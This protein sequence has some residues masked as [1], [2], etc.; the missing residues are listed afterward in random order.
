MKESRYN[1]FFQH[2]SKPDIMVCYNARTNALAKINSDLYEK[3]LEYVETKKDVLAAKELEDFI[4]GGFLINEDLDEIEILRERLLKRRYNGNTLSLTIT[5]TL[6]CNF[7][8]PYC[9]E[10]GDKPGKMTA[11]LQDKIIEMLNV[12]KNFINHFSVTWYGGE[13]L[14]A[15]DVIENLSTHFIEICKSNNIK[16]DASIVTNGYLLGRATCNK[17]INEL[18][19]TAIQITLDGPSEIHNKTRILHNGKGTFEQIL[20]N[21]KTSADLLENHTVIRTNV[22]KENYLSVSKLNDVLVKEGLRNKIR[23][24]FAII[25]PPSENYDSESCFNIEEF[26]HIN[27]SHYRSAQVPPEY[28]QLKENFCGAD[29]LNAMVIASDGNIYK[30]WHDVGI[31]DLSIGNLLSTVDQI[32]QLDYIKNKYVYTTYDP[33]IDNQCSDCDILPICMG[34]CPLNRIE[35]KDR[36]SPFKYNLKQTLEDYLEYQESTSI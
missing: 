22:N 9:Y 15:F 23:N 35:K 10:Q 17:L 30:C 18:N 32:K 28:P 3:Y 36:C 14:L 19:V 6:K 27:D 2:K 33:T 13:P 21:L 26:T 8:C 7:A 31:E 34:G 29:Y 25:R 20:E 24:Y 4:L 11:E 16:Y 12:Y 5:P 1:L